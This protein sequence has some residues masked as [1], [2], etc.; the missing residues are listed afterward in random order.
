MYQIRRKNTK[1]VADFRQANM[2]GHDNYG[3]LNIKIPR[4]V[5]DV[6]TYKDESKRSKGAL[7]V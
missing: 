1:C 3:Y 2:L 6:F 4:S 7:S 5:R